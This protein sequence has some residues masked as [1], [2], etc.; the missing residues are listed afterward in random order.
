MKEDIIWHI[1]ASTQVH[2]AVSEETTQAVSPRVLTFS[3][4]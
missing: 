2:F 4:R 3:A 1:A